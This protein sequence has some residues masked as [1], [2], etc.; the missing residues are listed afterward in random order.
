[1]DESILKELGLS[2]SEIKVYLALMRLGESTTGPIVD[3][4]GVAVS[5]VYTLLEKLVKKGLVSYT[6]KRKTRYF[7]PA[8]PSRL[9]D[10]HKEKE[11]ALERHRKE[12]TSVVKELEFLAGSAIKK[13]TFQLFEGLKGIQT[14]RERAL[15]EMSKGDEMW[16]V[17]IAKTPYEG[18]MTPYFKDFHNR[19][20]K[21][22]IKC[23]YLYNE[24][25]KEIAK[26]SAKY[27]HSEVK[28]MPKGLITHAWI[29]VYAN[30]V[31]IGINLRKSLSIVIDDPDIAA[32]FKIYAKLLWSGAK[33]L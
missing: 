30:T 17:G 12:L 22:G 25:A 16:V 11:E 29:E 33:K 13:E 26:E 4:S 5:K 7:I 20:S 15:K 23:K 6:L 10:Y 2:N 31:T 8:P 27:P 18:S 21:R 14:A 24:Y 9:L 1:M 19:R 3:E 28:L 32:S